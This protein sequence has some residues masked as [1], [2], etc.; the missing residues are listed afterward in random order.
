MNNFL[1][2]KDTHRL[3][4]E[5]LYEEGKPSIN[6]PQLNRV[7]QECDHGQGIIQRRDIVEFVDKAKGNSY[8]R[9]TIRDLTPKRDFLPARDITPRGRFLKKEITSLN[10]E[11]DDV[12]EIVNRIWYKYDTDRSGALNRRETL[13]FVDDFLG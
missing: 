11:E 9:K 8:N 6:Y 13:R 3:I 2:R 12:A 4:N 1:D 7:F 5:I 10:T